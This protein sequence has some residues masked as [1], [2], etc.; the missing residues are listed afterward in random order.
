MKKHNWRLLALLAA[1]GL[2][3]GVLFGGLSR[4]ASAPAEGSKF[5]P[6]K[7]C[8][9]PGCIARFARSGYLRAI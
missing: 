1:L 9:T 3:T 8:I 4:T 2:L 7:I 5:R 6:Q